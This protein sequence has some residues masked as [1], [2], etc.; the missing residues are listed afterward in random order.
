MDSK[1]MRVPLNEV[2]LDVVAL[3]EK[4]D[5]ERPEW[6]ELVKSVKEHGI[7]NPPSARVLKDGKYCIIDGMH[8][9]EA[10]VEAELEEIPLN[11]YAISGTDQEVNLAVMRLQVIGNVHKVDTRPVQ[12]AHQIQRMYINDPSLTTSDV[13]LMLNKSESWV[14]KVLNL[15]K[16]PDA[17]K[18]LVNRGSIPVSNAYALAKLP[19]EEINKGGW[20]ERA[21]SSDTETFFADATARA[22]AINKKPKNTGPEEFQAPMKLRTKGD[23]QVRLADMFEANVERLAPEELHSIQTDQAQAYNV[24]FTAGLMWALQQDPESVELAKQEHQARI[25]MSQRERAEKERANMAEKAAKKGISLMAPKGA[26][27]VRV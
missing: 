25:E 16:L 21:Q 26:T 9:F 7:L 17:V 22:K 11:V 24:G 4:V 6:A 20:V 15:N 27:A 13:A 10:A 2:V 19:E 14:N 5:K 3:R 1:L 12:Y 23:I 8:R 18:D